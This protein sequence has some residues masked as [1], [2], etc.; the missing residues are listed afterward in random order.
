M[1]IY[2]EEDFNIK[3]DIKIDKLKE[4]IELVNNGKKGI[5]KRVYFSYKLMRFYRDI[6]GDEII[7][8][9]IENTFVEI[10]EKV[11]KGDTE[12]FLKEM[13]KIVFL[14]PSIRGLYEE[15]LEEA[16]DTYEMKKVFK[17]NEKELKEFL[18]NV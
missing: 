11:Y 5:F 10:L 13:R 17:R 7:R 6:E 2:M 14:P 3:T 16:I 15:D 12:K 9:F 18:A 4:L 1:S 8:K